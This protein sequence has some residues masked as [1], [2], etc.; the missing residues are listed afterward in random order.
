VPSPN[1]RR[2]AGAAKRGAQH[3]QGSAHTH[4]ACAGSAAAGA[5]LHLMAQHPQLSGAW[6]R[7]D[8]YQ[9]ACGLAGAPAGLQLVWAAR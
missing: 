8:A 2:E 9:K 1:A 7:Q 5:P 4:A 6:A 3:A